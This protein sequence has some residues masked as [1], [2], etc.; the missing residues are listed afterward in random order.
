MQAAPHHH[1]NDGQH[2]ADGERN[3]P[4]PRPHLF[5]GQEELLQHQQHEDGAELTSDER[6]VMKAHVEAAVLM[7]GHFREVC[8]AGAV[9]A[10]EAQTLDD[11]RQT[12]EYRRCGANRSRG[13]CD[14][15]D[16][17]STAHQQ[18]RE[19]Q[20]MSSAVM[21]GEVPEQPATDRP[22]HEA[23]SKQ[24]RGV[25]LLHNRIAPGEERLGEIERK[26][27]V[28]VKVVPLDQIADGPDEYRL[29]SA[30]DVGHSERVGSHR[31]L[32]HV[33]HHT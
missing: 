18:H 9:L 25:Q 28:R 17:R 2:G 4:T 29:Q 11:A 23:S 33:A 10:A 22:H 7:V 16:Q 31:E 15:D 20:G 32:M 26:R 5:R 8:G 3:A 6:H 13:R 24:Q 14:R 27:R 12:E 21:V 19:H 30:L 1:G